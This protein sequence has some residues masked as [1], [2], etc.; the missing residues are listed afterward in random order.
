MRT[1][2]YPSRRHLTYS[3]QGL[4][5]TS[6]HL[7]ASVGASVLR[8]GGNA[9]D[10][11]L[12][13][14]AALTVVEPTSN[15]LGGDLFAIIS[16]GGQ[17]TGLN[18]SG[19]APQALTV[20]AIKAAGHKT[21]P[22]R[23]ALTVTVPG[24]TKGWAALNARFGSWTLAQ[25][26]EPAAQLAEEGYLLGPTVSA[27]WRDAHATFTDAASESWRQTFGTWRGEE[28]DF[29]CLPALAATLRAIGADGDYL[30][31]GLG[32]HKLVE[33]LTRQG[34]VMS[35]EDLAGFEPQWVDTLKGSWGD[36]EVHELPPNGHG[37]VVLQALGMLRHLPKAESEAEAVH[38]RIEAM[39]LAMTD[40]A[41][42][43]TEPSAM[44]CSVEQFLS[45]DYLA[46]RAQLIGQEARTPEAGKP[47]AGGT[48][49][50]CAADRWGMMVSLIQ[51]NYMGFGSG[52]VHPEL[53]VALHN[54]G[55]NFTLES[56]HPNNPGPGKRP[57]HT[58]IPAFLT[59]EGESF[60][61]FG[62]MGGFMQPQ[63]H[64]QVVTALAEG[65]NAQEALD[66]PRW[67]WEGGLKVSVEEGF[68]PALVEELRRRGHEVVVDPS[69]LD[70]G[71]GQ[72]IHRV[73]MGYVGATEPRAD[74]AVVAP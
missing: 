3:R 54:R 40:G 10:A 19:P 61:A 29:V 69:P 26:L 45:E 22:K 56:G 9:L 31:R 33:F 52:L 71:R 27:L 35:L 41:A 72:I 58:I 48:V 73:P 16:K 68:D 67:R 39:K 62:V 15:G 51:S 43:L 60:A 74:G 66:R 57:Y 17:I 12:A 53:W 37:A 49:Y 50:L 46:R 36:Y 25:T 7:A 21:M 42:H 13:T 5:A 44:D 2:R 30:Y 64:L 6:S 14:A 11:A 20:E 63:G 18:S 4:V 65:D 1:Y 32:A 8:Q 55:A 28:G 59:C 24:V 34:G 23:G 47:Q 38:Q 70:F